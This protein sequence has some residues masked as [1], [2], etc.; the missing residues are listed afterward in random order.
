M[1]RARIFRRIGAVVLVL[2][3]L[4]LVA[5]AATLALGVGVLKR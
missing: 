2:I 4:D 3:A 5:T 1:T